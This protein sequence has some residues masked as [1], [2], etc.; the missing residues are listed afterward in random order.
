MGNHFHLL[1]ET[2]NANLS[3]GMRQLNGVYAA[4]FN[5]RHNRAGHLFEGRFKAY[6]VDKDAYA[7]GV[8]RYVVLNP[9]RAGL[10]SHAREWRWSSYRATAGLEPP[11]RFLTIDWLLGQLSHDRTS[12]H[13]RYTAFVESALDNEA[14]PEPLG[15]LYLGTRRFARRAH[16]SPPYSPEIST[17]QQQAP[18]PSLDQVFSSGSDDEIGAAVHLHGYRLAEVARY[19]RVHPSTVTRRLRVYEAAIQDV[20]ERRRSRPDP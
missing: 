13:A 14:L 20:A 10:C 19:L 18:R 11:P 1:I 4:R 16:P 7:L 2:P 15:E 8:A 3:I 5:R 9:V 17:R 12:A 6:L